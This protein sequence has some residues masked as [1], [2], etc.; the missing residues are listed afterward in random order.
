MIFKASEKDLQSDGSPRSPSGAR[1]LTPIRSKTH[2]RH[3]GNNLSENDETLMNTATARR[4]FGRGR[5]S[6]ERATAIDS[7]IL[8]AASE[9]FLRDGFDLVTM[10][11]VA[12]ATPLSKTTLYSRFAS[13]EILLTAVIK[14]RMQQWSKASE[15]QNHLMTEDLGDR[16]RYHARSITRSLHEPDVQ[17][18]IR[19]SYL[20]TE[21]FPELSRTMYEGYKYTVSYI[22]NDL[23]A[24]S[25]RDGRPLRDADSV[26]QHF[27]SAVI[28]WNMQEAGRGGASVDEADAAAVRLAE[29]F[30]AARDAW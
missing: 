3:A 13:K 26:A 12:N 2:T 14:D 27:V 5:P 19:L 4:V 24:A 25:K 21:R 9:L 8:V 17:G 23:A 29:L 7:A 6:I 11:A 15:Q 30:L 1:D 20:L 10:E 22:G 28:G 18:F 16:L